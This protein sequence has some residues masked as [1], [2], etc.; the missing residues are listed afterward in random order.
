MFCSPE[1]THPPANQPTHPPDRG[2]AL[3]NVGN[4]ESAL[5]NGENAL[6]NGENLL[7]NGE[8]APPAPPPRS[9][10]LVLAIAPLII[11]SQDGCSGGSG[12][13]PL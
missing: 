9:L 5:E 3:E 4:G 1:P 2:R 8:N 13:G 6:E 12:A 10:R 7:E 11:H